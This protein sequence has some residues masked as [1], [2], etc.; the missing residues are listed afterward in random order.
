M[1]G[2]RSVMGAVLAVVRADAGFAPRIRQRGLGDL[3]TGHLRRGRGLGWRSF[4]LPRPTWTSKGGLSRADASDARRGS[5]CGAPAGCDI[6]GGTAGRGSATRD[7]RS[8]LTPNAYE[9]ATVLPVVADSAAAA[10]PSTSAA[11]PSSK[12]GEQDTPSRIEVAKASSS[13]GR[14]GRSAEEERQIRRSFLGAGGGVW[15]YLGFGDVACRRHSSAQCANQ[16]SQHQA[17]ALPTGH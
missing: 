17:L 3:V 10:L 16:P 7:R 1:G 6:R 9:I 4:R 5:R 15:A 14:P 13:I 11:T 8:S 12:E 2:D